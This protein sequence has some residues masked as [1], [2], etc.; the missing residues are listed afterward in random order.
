MCVDEKYESIEIIF[1]GMK[2]RV[3]GGNKKLELLHRLSRVTREGVN[4]R[5]SSGYVG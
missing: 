5:H 4:I 1:H 2:C 3:G